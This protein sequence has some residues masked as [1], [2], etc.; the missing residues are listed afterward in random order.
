M[1]NRNITLGK[2]GEELAV[3]FLKDNGYKIIAHN[4]KCKLG[5]IDIIAKDRKTICFIEVKTRNTERFGLPSEAIS[6][7]KQVH[8]ARAALFFLKENRLLN[9][10]A[11]FDVVCLSCAQGLP[12]IELI[13]DA[14]ELDSGYTY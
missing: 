8:L 4:Y 1:F 9:Q 14:F 5:E 10:R 12:R 7:K 11:R 6:G 3:D 2:Q 13:K